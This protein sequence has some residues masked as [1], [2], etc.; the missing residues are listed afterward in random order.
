MI[1]DVQL[2]D[3]IAHKDT[4]LEFG[5]GITIF[6][7]HN[8]SGKSSIIDAVTFALFG[9]HTRK[10]NKN[11]VRRG[12]NSAM[13]QMRFALNSREYQATRALNGSGLQSFS[14]FTIISEGG[15]LV[16]RPI[17]GGERKQFGESMSSEIAKVLGLDYEKLRVA[18]VV[19]QGELV[20]IVEAQPKEFKELVNG[21][22]G[23]D[24]LDSAFET[25]R[26]VIAGFRDRL[27]DETGGHTDTDIPKVE[28]LISR[29]E[30]ELKQSKS[31]LAEFEDERIMLEDRIR[32]VEQEI[33][34]MEPLILQVRELQTREELLVRHVNERRSLVGSEV[35]RLE[36][37]IKEA[38]GSLEVLKGK[39]EVDMRLQMSRSEIDEVQSKIVENEGASGELRGF[40]DCS[41][42]LQMIDGRCPVC[43]SPVAKINEMFDTSHIQAEIRRKA[44]EKSR[45]QVLKVE[46]KKE[47]QQLAE[48]DKKIA[49]AEKFLSNNAIGSAE[50]LARLEAELKS[51]QQ[52]LE[53]LPK[54]IIKAGDD[55]FQIAIDDSSR[56]LASE[57]ASLRELVRGFSRHQHS[58]AKLEKSKLSQ[59]LLD[60]NRKMGMH[61]KAIDDSKGTIDSSRKVIEELQKAAEFVRTLE[62]I[63]SVI[64]ARDGM[65]GISLRS[66]ALGVISRQASEYASLF[67]IG[68]SRIELSEGAREIAIMCYGRQGEIDMDSLSGGEKVAVALALRLGIAYMMGSSKLDF[69]ILDEPTTHLDEERR[70]A[71]VRIISEAFREGAGPLAQLIIITHDSDIFEDS[72][73]DQIFR[74]AMTSEGSCVIPE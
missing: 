46:L 39:G 51:T 45:L 50:D 19:Q 29:K 28:E 4:K 56:T 52:D 73:V 58:N 2:K 16:N 65:V 15:N 74:F 63:R 68:I 5:K 44:D 21:L 66:W 53:R 40:L 23:I 47:E 42:R 11:L 10:S 34:R 12:A 9:K 64:F 3:F 14:Q 7:G 48:Q 33:E 25:M 35:S 41:D 32:Q 57:I 37:I 22:I 20:K 69:V 1:K 6:V 26:E 61:Q 30:I 38:A 70:K 62:K 67:N 71:L 54:E 36:R 17:V 60:I 43:N 27:R 31:V 24:R 59:R 72:E 8:G 49:A 18:A 55:P 13:V